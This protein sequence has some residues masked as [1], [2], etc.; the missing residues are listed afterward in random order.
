LAVRDVTESVVEGFSKSTITVAAKDVVNWNAFFRQVVRDSQR[1][2]TIWTAVW[3]VIMPARSQSV[4][5]FVS[6]VDQKLHGIAIPSQS[7]RSREPAGHRLWC[8]R[9]P[10]C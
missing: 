2:V 7:G 6:N 9:A 1:V 8:I 10:A 4:R 3:V 5:L